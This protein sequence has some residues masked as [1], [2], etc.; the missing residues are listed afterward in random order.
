MSANTA[1]TSARATCDVK[2]GELGMGLFAGTSWY[3]S[4]YR[5]GYPDA[6]IDWIL[7]RFELD[8]STHV[9]DLGCGTGQL[10]IPLAARGVLVHAVDPDAEMLAEGVRAAEA[11]GVRGIDWIRGD[12]KT[13]GRLGLPPLKVCVM[14]SSFHWM[15]RDE[16]LKTLDR[17]I[18]P[19]GGVA[20]LS[21]GPGLWP[22]IGQNLRDAGRE[23]VL[24]ETIREVIVDF[25]G[26]ERRAG[27]GTY[28]HPED[29]HEVVLGR[30]PFHHVEKTN[31]VTPQELTIEQMVGLQLSTSYASPALLGSRLDDFKKALTERL[32]A[33][34]PSGVFRGERTI[35]ALI[36]T[37]I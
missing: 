32:A 28:T 19:R 29:T 12:D 24:F 8:R 20:I 7:R 15:D 4:R 33:I 36:G 10:A 14:G 26:P 31:F 9:L 18:L 25:L 23:K 21:G 2:I 13:A 27:S 17:M 5:L 37:R 34:E 35:E 22:K 1:R 16:A 6:A 11:A 30:S 3:Y